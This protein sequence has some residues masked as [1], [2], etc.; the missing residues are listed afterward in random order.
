M[1][2]QQDSR[3]KRRATGGKRAAYRKHRKF[4]LGRQPALT[5]LGET[6]V[7]QIRVRGGNIKLRALR[8]DSGIFSWGSE[9]ISRKSRID[10]VVYNGANNEFV[11]TNTLVKG[12]IIKIDAAPYRLW[13]ES[14]YGVPIKTVSDSVKISKTKAPKAAAPAKDAKAAAPAKDA[15]AAA[16]AKDAKAAAPAKGAA[17]DAKEAAPAKPAAKDAKPAA[18]DAKAKAAATGVRRLSSRVSGKE[19]GIKTTSSALA[20]Y[21]QRAHKRVLDPVFQEQFSSGFLLAAIASRPGQVGRVDGYLLEGKELEFY[22]KKTQKKK[23][24]K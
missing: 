6:R 24:Q 17:K 23:S 4:R 11:R 12:E 3:H 9:G 18:K 13:Y 15:K 1:G 20:R 2:I 21:R 10:S 5:K 19:G 16:P 22:L 14:Y 7:R 8:L